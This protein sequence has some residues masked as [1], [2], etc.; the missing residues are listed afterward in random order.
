M[1][2]DKKLLIMR[3]AKSDRGEM[4]QTDFDRP[5]NHRGEHEPKIIAQQLNALSISIDRALVSPAVRTTQTWELLAES[6]ANIPDV[7]FD[8]TLYNAYVDDI[9]EA[10]QQHVR[11]DQTLILIAHNPGVSELCSYLCGENIEFEPATLAILHTNADDITSRLARP[12]GFTLERL[13]VP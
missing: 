4:M 10:L 6:L 13:L 9:L 5:L 1:H 11:D 7:I 8:R 2:D 12:K 3:H